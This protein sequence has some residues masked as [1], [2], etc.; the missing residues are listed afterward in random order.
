MAHTTVRALHHYDDIGL[1]VPSRTD[2]GYRSY[3]ET[4]LARLREILL[5]REL[6][7]PLSEIADLLDADAST[8]LEILRAHRDR[9]EA[10][11]RR[12]REA[13]A[14]IDHHIDRMEETMN[15]DELF[16][17]FEHFDQSEYAGEAKERWGDTPEY[18]ESTRRTRS[19]GPEDWKRIKDE[20]RAHME[21]LANLIREGRTPLEPE[22][23]ALA[24]TMR[25][26]IDRWFYPCSHWM[27]TQLASMYEQD[28]RFKAA[29]DA[30]GEEG[31]VF[32]ATAIRENARRN[33]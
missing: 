14:A 26:H 29:Y 11:V 27:H 16:E 33:G 7:V 3:T 28:P 17:G 20:G 19:Y 10:E 9:Y 12:A 1:L 2:G 13:L 22:S 4:D 21:N 31:A 6:G 23:L 30:A 25:G 18:V 5:L 24:E 32:I 8:R 15:T